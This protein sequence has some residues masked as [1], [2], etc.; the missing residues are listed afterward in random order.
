MIELIKRIL[1]APF[2]A[3][4]A[5]VIGFSEWL[6]NPLLRAIKVITRWGPIAWLENQI[7]AL[8]SWASLLMFAI[9]AIALLP[10]KLAGLYFLA[11]GKKV[12]GLGIFFAAKIVGTGLLAWIYSLTE[13]ALERYQWFISVRGFYRKI[14]TIVYER[15]KSSFVWQ[16][17]KLAWAVVKLKVKGL[18]S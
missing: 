5:L 8:P 10:F 4:A 9:P 14:K 17:S 11:N 1:S 18:F 6:W 15:V 16:Q 13:R 12:L 3:V 2:V 7:R